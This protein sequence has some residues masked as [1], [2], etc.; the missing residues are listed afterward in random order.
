MHIIAIIPLK[1]KKMGNFSES[2]RKVKNWE[3]C[4]LSSESESEFTSIQ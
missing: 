3:C 1:R 4:Q 2:F